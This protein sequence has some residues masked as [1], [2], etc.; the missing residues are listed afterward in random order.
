MP[1]KVPRN[2]PPLPPKLHNDIGLMTAREKLAAANAKKVGAPHS[3][4]TR[5][6]P[7]PERPR[8]SHGREEEKPPRKK[9]AQASEVNIA[10]KVHILS[11]DDST[12]EERPRAD[13]A[14]ERKSQRR[15]DSI[16]DLVPPPLTCELRTIDIRQLIG[17]IKPILE[18]PVR[19]FTPLI[20]D[21]SQ[22]IDLFFQY[23]ADYSGIFVE[24]KKILVE[25]VIQK[26]V[27][28]L[29]ALEGMRQQ[30]VQAMK[31]GRTLVVRMADSAIHFKT[32]F[33][34]KDYFPLELFEAG[35]RNMRK[36][37]IYSLVIRPEDTDK[38]IFVVQPEFCVVV[39]SMFELEDFQE[40]LEPSLPMDLMIPIFI[41][42][43]PERHQ[44]YDA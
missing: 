9:I 34:H 15:S 22:R 7:V 44:E 29:Q 17:T 14:K 23:S 1:L 16:E 13:L 5:S 10:N 32:T 27:T 6:A 21:P 37:E 12:G 2:L 42:P 41:L 43:S 11:L 36:E 35:G 30:L 3:L 24:A 4:A 38:G 39:T 28:H 31:Y 20:I 40:F 26:K 19:A 18:H 25:S 8:T 33:S